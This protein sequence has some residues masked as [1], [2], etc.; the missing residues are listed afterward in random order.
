MSRKILGPCLVVGLALLCS[1]LAGSSPGK[2]SSGAQAPPPSS[3][4][5]TLTGSL[6]DPSIDYL[7]FTITGANL[8]LKAGTATSYEGTSTGSTIT[9]VGVMTATHPRGYNVAME[10]WLDDQEVEW[11]GDLGGR[12]F[13]KSFNLTFKIGPSPDQSSITAAVRVGYCAILNG[14]PTGCGGVDVDFDIA[15]KPPLPAPVVQAYP[16]KKVLKP[17]TD[18]R[19]VLSVK[20]ES[21]KARV[22]GRL[23]EGGKAIRGLRTTT[24]VTADG[25]K[26]DWVTHLSA[27]RTGPLR[28]CIWAENPAG[29]KSVNAPKSSC[30]W[31][32][33]LVE[34]ARV[35]N[36]CGGEGWDSIVAI[37]NKFGNTSSYYDLDQ[38]ETYTVDFSDACDLHD[39]GYGGYM[40]KDT[41]NGGV[42]NFRTYSREEIDDK[43]QKDM[44]TLCHEKIPPEAKQARQECVTGITRYTIVRTV[45]Y[46][47]FDADLTKPGTQATGHRD[48]S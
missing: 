37:E 3:S 40:V 47:F 44:Q 27:D 31:L 10:A 35:S 25:R 38:D 6:G 24:F 7:K 42:P 13:S 30:A 21:G 15:L 48:N 46:Q 11:I 29:T 43:F 34:I 5:G 8:K 32:S 16:V 45:G 33:F 17:G 41:I 20:D 2:V 28:F 9:L 14:Q 19:L 22:N 39:A 26:Y 1:P 18:A 4:G 12:T 23:Y 36:H